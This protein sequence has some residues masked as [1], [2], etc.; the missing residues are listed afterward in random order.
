MKKILSVCLVLVMMLSVFGITA[1]AE[2]IVGY[3]D[4][5]IEDVYYTIADDYATVSGYWLESE[6][7]PQGAVVIPEK[8]T[9]DGQDY[10]VQAVDGNAFFQ[11][12]FTS[13]T[14]P[15]T[16]NY[17]GNGAFSS[18]DYLT[19]I[20]IPDEC[21]FNY[22]GSGVFVGSPVEEKFVTQECTIFG[23]NVLFAYTGNAD[24]FVVPE[25]IDT[26]I[27]YC[28]YLSG[29]KSV[30]LNDNIR[31]IPQ[32]CFASCTN[33]KEIAIPDSVQY[34]DYGAFQDCINLEKVTLG[35]GV[36][37]LG[38]NCFKNT[39]IKS[40]HL[41]PAV[42]YIDGAF[43]D[44]KLENITVDSENQLLVKNGD[45]IYKRTFMGGDDTYI[46]E[47]YVFDK[48]KG[49]IELP[50]FVGAIGSYVFYGCKDLEE[51]TANTLIYIDSYA[52]ANSGLKKIDFRGAYTIYE[53]AFKNCKNLESIN[54]EETSYIDNCVFQNCTSLTNVDFAEDIVNIGA[55]S[56]ANTGL[57]EAEIIGYNCEVQESAFKDC[58][59][60]ET[61]VLDD[62]VVSLGKNVFLNCPSLTSVYLTKTIDF[63]DKN[64][65]NGCDD[66]MFSVI[67]STD[68]HRYVRKYGY[69][70]EVVG[71][72]SF[73]GTIR[74]FF[75]GISEA[76]TEM[77][78]Q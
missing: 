76:I 22:F 74:E 29:V 42:S 30:V 61:V 65:L 3:S 32:F 53:G 73:F 78:E 1:F 18:C 70:F 15:S 57:S 71:R 21:N 23:E 51:V 55:L 63:I 72:L 26:I 45:G 25:E 44:C 47:Y 68:A 38:E 40:I 31:W 46:L 58:Q 34:I 62:G 19:D 7:E 11:S 35:D 6:T 36:F 60:L 37:S 28:F 8:I 67:K 64:A 17:I 5:R 49:K 12:N 16:V 52:F 56:F 50:S 9:Y 33:L 2:P 75:E 43:K 54:I 4:I 20:V 41:G 69:D 66:V 59:N 24:E 77:F 27:E 14:L 48:A 10:P 13:V 39:K